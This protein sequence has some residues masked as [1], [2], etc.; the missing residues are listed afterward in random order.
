MYMHTLPGSTR[1]FLHLFMSLFPL[2]QK[3]MPRYVSLTRTGQPHTE[4]SPAPSPLT[5]SSFNFMAYS[6]ITFFLPCFTTLSNFSLAV[7][8]GAAGRHGGGMPGMSHQCSAPSQHAGRLRAAVHTSSH[9]LFGVGLGG[10]HF[11]QLTTALLI[12]NLRSQLK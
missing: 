5:D 6:D 3:T 1:F 9:H 10:N 7:T 11:F 2:A 12:V 8:A 4:I